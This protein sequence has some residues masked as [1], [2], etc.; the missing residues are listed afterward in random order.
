MKPNKYS[1]LF[2]TLVFLFVFS[3]TFSQGRISFEMTVNLGSFELVGSEGGNELYVNNPT[4][5]ENNTAVASLAGA[6]GSLNFKLMPGLDIFARYQYEF[7]NE[8][9]IDRYVI[10]ATDIGL[11]YAFFKE[12]MF[13]PMAKVS[14]AKLRL[15]GIQVYDPELSGQDKTKENS[16]NGFGI[17]L[18]AGLDLTL[19]NRLTCTL[20]YNMILPTALEQDADN[21]ANVD[22]ENMPSIG[23]FSFSVGIGL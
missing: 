17:G 18:S 9:L 8:E 2:A 12:G 19:G 23:H 22:L 5:R 4:P 10:T 1:R 3:Q 7:G 16:Y 21:R 20:A 14:F 6:G 11:R 13:H 15:D